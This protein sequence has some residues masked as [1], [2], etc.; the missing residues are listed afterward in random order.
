MIIITA[1]TIIIVTIRVITVVITT[2]L[3]TIIIHRCYLADLPG[4]HA[5]CLLPICL[6]LQAF[7]K[8]TA[9]AYAL[10]LLPLHGS[11]RQVA[12]TY[13]YKRVWSCLQAND[14]LDSGMENRFGPFSDC[15]KSHVAV[16]PKKGTCNINAS[17]AV[18]LSLSAHLVYAM[19]SKPR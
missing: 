15:A 3:T 2:V 7:F 6:L 19:Q 11:Q 5:M 13:V 8:A 18:V 12:V 1:M 16:K 14:W 10:D 9:C 4:V 17:C